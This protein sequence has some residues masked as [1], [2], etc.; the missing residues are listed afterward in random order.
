MSEEHDWFITER[1]EALASLLLTSRPDLTVRSEKKHDDGVDFVVALK[2]PN[3]TLTT[4]IFI[5][6]VKGTLSSDQKRWT[7][8]VKQLYRK[9]N[10]FYLPACVF[11]VNVR[12]NDAAYAWVAEPK[13]NGGGAR[14]NFFQH[15]EFHA[16]D[17]KAVDQI[18][19]RV[20]TWYD[21]M[22]RSFASHA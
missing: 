15:P 17:A 4:K 7:E 12:S 5:V 8:N 16:L 3:D 20:R 11:I 13:V 9:S 22:P 19:G 10:E 1:S 18:V 2:E 21:S 6:Q 14:L